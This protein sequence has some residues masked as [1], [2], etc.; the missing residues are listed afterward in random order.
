MTILRAHAAIQPLEEIPLTSRNL[1]ERIFD[2]LQQGAVQDP[3]RL[4]LSWFPQAKGKAFSYAKNYSFR[5]LLGHIRQTANLFDS[6]GVESQDVI[7]RILPNMPEVHW[8][9]W[10]GSC[11]G[12]VCPIDPMMETAQMQT[13]LQEL[14]PR[15]L[16]TLAPFPKSDL[17]DKIEEVR[18]SIDSLEQ[19]VQ[20]QL[21]DHMEGMTRRLL[22]FSGRKKAK[23]IAGQ[24][25]LD[26][27]KE[28]KRFPKDRFAFEPSEDAEAIAL[29]YPLLQGPELHIQAYSHR[30]LIKNSWCLGQMWQQPEDFKVL[31]CRP[32]TDA[33]SLMLCALQPWS[34]GQAVC[35]S[36]PQAYRSAGFVG[37]FF[38][39]L[40]HY[41]ISH[42]V[43]GHELLY[44]LYEKCDQGEQEET[45]PFAIIGSESLPAS[46]HAYFAE[47]GHF[48]ILQLLPSVQAVEFSAFLAE[49][50]LHFLPFQAIDPTSLS[51]S[52]QSDEEGKILHLHP[53]LSLIKNSGGVIFP[54]QV[55]DVMLQHP[56][57]QQVIA[58]GSPDLKA[59]EVAAI[60]VVAK[61]GVALG[62][63]EL[64]AFAQQHMTHPGHVPLAFHVLDELPFLSSGDIDR[65]TLYASEIK[66]IIVRESHKLGV[67]IANE[68]EI[69]FPTH[70]A[71][72]PQIN[73]MIHSLGNET[74]QAKLR[75][76][77]S[78]LPYQIQFSDDGA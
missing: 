41:E 54:Q 10:G 73:V 14:A 6:L 19:I 68:V 30:T 8:A 72:D 12:A 21:A 76:T 51:L 75:A 39:I 65:L 37:N 52:I 9:M 74:A 61:A 64:Y 20:V 48:D 57:V 40:A 60:F 17:W 5:Q 23:K 32:A 59:G 50:H 35:L 38:H 44:A 36:P 15:V 47:N 70:T 18:A 56:A 24:T 55:E 42:F 28:K 77:F 2:L 45:M 31:C 13:L 25:I 27:N 69:S 3:E 7:A 62:G 67:D 71:M 58:T 22:K 78:L 53:A 49:E 46:L 63:K 4:A 43:T 29:C 33:Y 34:M 11:V 16:I 1:P 66:R 26:F